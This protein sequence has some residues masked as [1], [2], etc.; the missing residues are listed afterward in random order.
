LIHLGFELT[1]G[2]FLWWYPQITTYSV[3]IA[4]FE[5]PLDAWEIYMTPTPSEAVRAAELAR[6][7][8]NEVAQ[9]LANLDSVRPL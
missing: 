4:P 7:N 2:E 6:Q 1:Y 3:A 8:S 5:P 9:I